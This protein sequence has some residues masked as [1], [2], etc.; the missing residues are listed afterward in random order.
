MHLAAQATRLDGSRKNYFCGAVTGILFGSV[1]LMG[2]YARGQAPSITVQPQSTAVLPGPNITFSVTASGANPLRY[3][4]RKDGSSLTQRTNASLTI[5]SAQPADTAAYSVVVSNA[6][7][8]VT[9]APAFLR[10]T[11]PATAY[12]TPFRPGQLAEGLVG[13]W[14]LDE[15]SGQRAD[16]SGRG[17]H[18]ADN[19]GV[20]SVPEDYWG[21]GE[22]SADFQRASSQFL[23]VTH[24]AQN[25]L[26]LTNTFTLSAWIR[27]RTLVGTGI[28]AGKWTPNTGYMIHYSADDGGTIRTFVNGSSTTKIVNDLSA[29]ALRVIV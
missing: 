24:A 17:N 12:T 22:R 7:G 16:S 26:S 21:S 29:Q 13:W 25:G 1:L 11:D 2:T 9:S 15:V 27:P 14:K 5:S 19:N 6:V 23:S 28:V 10:V 8:S 4:W 18:L 20:G 3:Q